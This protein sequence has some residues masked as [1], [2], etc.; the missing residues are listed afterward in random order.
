MHDHRGA[1]CGWVAMQGWRRPMALNG[2]GIEFGKSEH[3]SRRRI[4]RATTVSAVFIVLGQRCGVQVVHQKVGHTTRPGPLCRLC[5]NAEKR[6]ATRPGARAA[7]RAGTPQAWSTRAES[8]HSALLEQPSMQPAV[9]LVYLT[10]PPL[11][12][13]RNSL[14]E[15]QKERPANAHMDMRWKPPDTGHEKRPPGVE[16]DKF[17]SIVAS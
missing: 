3:D 6:D 17:I 1:P 4:S 10:V 12:K 15:Q 14:G 2:T 13:F 7:A 8:A 5:K 9:I 11:G 16:N